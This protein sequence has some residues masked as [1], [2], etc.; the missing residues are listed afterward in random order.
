MTDWQR[1]R[2][3]IFSLPLRGGDC[4]RTPGVTSCPK[5]DARAATVFLAGAIP[6]YFRM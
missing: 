2:L 1:K 6:H 4:G 3:L 5:M